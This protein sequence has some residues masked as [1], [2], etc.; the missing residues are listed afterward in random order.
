MRFLYFKH[1]LH[2]TFFNNKL[3]YSIQDA[4]IINKNRY[5]FGVIFDKQCAKFKHYVQKNR[6]CLNRIIH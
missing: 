4:I 6:H 1:L 5:S 2:S 3:N